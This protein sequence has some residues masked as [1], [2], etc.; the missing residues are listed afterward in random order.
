MHDLIVARHPLRKFE[1]QF[2]CIPTGS[3]QPDM[4]GMG[5]GVRNRNGV[6]DLGLIILAYCSAGLT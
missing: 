6:I 3:F 1:G 4:V 2:V 5:S